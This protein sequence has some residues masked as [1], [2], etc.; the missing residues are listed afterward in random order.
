M[1]YITNSLYTLLTGEY[2][3]GVTDLDSLINPAIL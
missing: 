2:I 1:N 3:E